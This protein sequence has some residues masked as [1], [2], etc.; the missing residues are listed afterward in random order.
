VNRNGQ[1][2]GKMHFSTPT[3]MEERLKK[4]GIKVIDDQI[5]DFK[6]NYWDPSVEL[7]LE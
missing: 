5:Q 7:T 2:T 1:L 4:E 6:S 3:Q